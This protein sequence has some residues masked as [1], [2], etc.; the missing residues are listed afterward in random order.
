M[1]PAVHALIKEL[2]T[3]ARTTRR[4]LERVPADRFDWRPHPKSMTAG[5]LARHIAT[6]P[7]SIARVMALDGLD[8]STRP[9][10][11]P[12]AE[13]TAALL[14]ALDASVEAARDLLASLDE[15]RA[16]ATWRLTF[17]DHEVFALPRVVAFRTMA[18]NHWYH[19]RGELV[20]YLRLLEVPVPVVYGRSA[21]ENPFAS[22][23]A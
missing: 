20:V 8:L 23:V 4:V 21:D 13:S 6:V 17:G 19:H 14:D 11:Y 5:Q 9:V 10:E 18:L 16:F 3:E 12:P 2:E 7:G 22:L 15:A 1:L